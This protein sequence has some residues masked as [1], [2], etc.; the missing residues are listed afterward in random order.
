MG[1][2]RADLLCKD[3]VTDRWVLVGN[4]LE[5]T[6]HGHLGQLMTYAAGL[7]AVTIVWIASRFTDEH[8]AALD[9]LN[10]VTDDDINFF[11]LEIE[12]WQIGDSPKAPKFNVVSQPN[13]WSKAIAAVAAHVDITDTKRLQFDYW[14]GLQD[15]LL[16]HN[17]EVI[18]PQKPK[19]Q[20]K[21]T[22]PIGRSKVHLEALI[23]TREGTISIILSLGGT[24]A[25][26][27]YFLLFDQK[28]A[29]E[30]EMNTRLNWREQPNRK[31]SRIELSLTGENLAD[32]SCWP[33]QYEW[34]RQNL[35][36]FHRVFS[37]R[38]KKLDVRGA[39]VERSE[40]NGDLASP[41]SP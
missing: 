34:L 3:T 7:N 10:E 1:P 27:N 17:S 40:D 20:Q 13:N 5:R 8:R 25:K 39:E 41:T 11:G 28:D 24:N 31:E 9:W 15:Y 14:R 23:N 2:F 18:K 32:R 37:G 29:V 35:E 36:A 33:K 21:I 4:Q 38:V 26:T 16:E 6:D 30:Q 12:L 19:P 22:F